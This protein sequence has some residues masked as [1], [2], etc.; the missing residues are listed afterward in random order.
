MILAAEKDP[1]LAG[2]LESADLVVADGAGVSLAARMKG[3]T[4]PRIP[5]IELMEKLCARA[6]ARD[7]RVFL[8][9]AAPGV[10][11][12]AAAVLRAKYPGLDV[13]GTR[14][15]YFSREE[16]PEVL[17]Q[18]SRAAPDLLFVALD[19][20]R[21][22]VWI[23]RNLARLNARVAMGVGGSFD[24]ISGRLY[25]APR[26]MSQTGLEWLYRLIQEPRRLRRMA[27]LP[28]FFLKALFQKN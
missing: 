13:A 5:G 20:P 9:G 11:D 10:A 8:L 28:V 12:R 15:G 22:D 24:V 17:R 16:E 1:G 27:G 23:H 18:V 7:W 4:L 21:Q 25:R 2:A 6:V 19:V 26:W 3:R 14:H